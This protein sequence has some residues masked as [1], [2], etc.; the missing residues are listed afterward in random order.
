MIVGNDSSNYRNR[1]GFTSQ[2]VLVACNFD[3]EFIY[4]LNGWEGSAHDS[5]ILTDALS[6]RNRLKVPQG[7]YFLVDYGF[8][9]RRQ[10]LAPFRGVRHHLFDFTG[11]RRH[12]ENANELFNL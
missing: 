12:P 9:N 6:R 8:P 3:L 10:F 4:V 11:Q 5:R 7:K 2:N 1:H